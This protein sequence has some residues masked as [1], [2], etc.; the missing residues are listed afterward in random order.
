VRER[1]ADTPWFTQKTN[2]ALNTGLVSLTK[3]LGALS[4]RVKAQGA[5]SRES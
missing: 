3:A 1:E 4:R 2:K 5:F